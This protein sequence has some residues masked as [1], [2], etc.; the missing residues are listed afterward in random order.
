[1]I[2]NHQEVV[3]MKCR[4]ENIYSKGIELYLDGK[5]MS[6]AGIV[7]HFVHEESV[8]MPD[9]VLDEDGVLTQIRYDKVVEK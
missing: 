4:L 3:A 7:E 2:E 1:M 6:P 5:P 8:Y 9:F